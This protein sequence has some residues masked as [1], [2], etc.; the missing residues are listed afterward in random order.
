MTVSAILAEKGSGVIT[1][2]NSSSVTQIIN[3]LA[4][5]KIGS[6]LITDD[7]G[8]VCGIVSER[9][10]VRDI[11]IE[12]PAALEAN[13]SNCMTAKVIFCTPHNTVSEVMAM[14]TENRFRHL[15]VM[16]DGKLL[17]LVSIGDV[18]KRKIQDAE[19]EA[20]DMRSYISTV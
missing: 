17:G 9:D 2:S 8:S 18:V 7:S 5:K 1:A 6:V 4:E 12:G 16:E 10:I 13:V 15:P 19:K 11:A 20:D 3:L 14:M